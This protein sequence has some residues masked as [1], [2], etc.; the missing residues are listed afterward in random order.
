MNGSRKKARKAQEQSEWLQTF[1]EATAGLAFAPFELFR[2]YGFLKTI[3]Q[4]RAPRRG[5]RSV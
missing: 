2:G 1:S 4:E 3:W 5:V